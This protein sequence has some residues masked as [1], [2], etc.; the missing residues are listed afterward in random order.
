MYECATLVMQYNNGYSLYS[1]ISINAPHEVISD[2]DLLIFIP[3]ERRESTLHRDGR[4]LERFCV[5]GGCFTFHINIS[6]LFM[7]VLLARFVPFCAMVVLPKLHTRLLFP[8]QML[9][10]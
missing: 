4:Y 6:L 3:L 9:L 5:S 1:V 10:T 8:Y 2:I 7:N